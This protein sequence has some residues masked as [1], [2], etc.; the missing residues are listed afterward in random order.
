LKDVILSIQNT[1]IET[2]GN[3]KE[4]LES[5]G[6]EIKTIDVKRDNIPHD[7]DEYAAIVILGGYMSVYENLPYLNKEQE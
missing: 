2:L 4:L 1:E 7:S 5:D 6:Y 3:L